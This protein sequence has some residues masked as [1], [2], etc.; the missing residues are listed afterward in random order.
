MNS[1]SASHSRTPTDQADWIMRVGDGPYGLKGRVPLLVPLKEEG[2]QHRETGRRRRGRS[3]RGERER[4][5][6]RDID[7]RDTE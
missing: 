5:T 6:Q 3:E 2:E 1:T 7:R 4:E